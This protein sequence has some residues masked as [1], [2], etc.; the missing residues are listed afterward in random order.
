MLETPDSPIVTMDG[1][2][3]GT[4]S[5]MSPEQAEGRVDELG[6]RSDVYSIGA[7]LYELVTGQPPY[8]SRG[9]KVSPHTVLAALLHGP[10]VPIREIARDRPVELE[11]ICNK[12]MARKAAA[13]YDSMQSLRG[14]LTSFLAGEPV[15]AC[16]YSPIQ[17]AQSEFSAL[18]RCVEFGSV[19]AVFSEFSAR[20]Q[21]PLENSH[22]S[23]YAAEEG[24]RSTSM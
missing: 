3:V 23:A 22:Y 18:L 7:M 5:Y 11:A 8:C 24:P 13:R 17:R 1:A 9:A 14:D 20:S 4:P 12:A 15:D 10:P 16:K 19:R 2:V 21:L 6:A